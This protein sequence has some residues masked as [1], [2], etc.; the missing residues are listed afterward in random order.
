MYTPKNDSDF[1]NNFKTL[2]SENRKIQSQNYY[3]EYFF[4]KENTEERI[5]N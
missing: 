4:V 5:E 2:T 1:V 3:Q